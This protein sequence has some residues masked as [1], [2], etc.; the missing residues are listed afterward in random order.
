MNK[1]NS[2][3]AKS[4]RNKVKDGTDNKTLML[5]QST[6]ALSYDKVEQVSLIGNYQTIDD[7]RK[8]NNHNE[9]DS[10]LEMSDDQQESEQLDS[11]KRNFVETLN[12]TPKQHHDL[13]NSPNT[14][15]YLRIRNSGDVLQNS[16]ISDTT[17][18]TMQVSQSIS[19]LTS[20]TVR[21]PKATMKLDPVITN[22][23]EFTKTKK[24]KSSTLSGSVYDLEVVNQKDI[25][26]N[27]Y[28]TISSQ[29]VTLF[30][31]KESHF[32]LMAQWDREFELFQRVSNIHFFKLYK[33]WKV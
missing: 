21:L 5:S 31:N 3:L 13:Y 24:K 12:L 4:L 19:S 2:S 27:Y 14:F 8:S 22:T 16:L 28:F 9:N 11:I 20:S 25:D 1:G 17:K 7:N 29:G 18:K 33:R 10:K 30:H 6:S 23:S 15:F 26:K 32:T